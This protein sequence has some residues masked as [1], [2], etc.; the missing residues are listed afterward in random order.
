MIVDLWGDIV[1]LCSFYIASYRLDIMFHHI[2]KIDE[3]VLLLLFIENKTERNFYMQY[4]RL[5]RGD[6]CCT[7]FDNE[8]TLRKT[9]R[10]GP[11]GV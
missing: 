11:S 7:S 2:P 8:K 1:G 10:V 6:H 4:I 3:Q 9:K 5:P